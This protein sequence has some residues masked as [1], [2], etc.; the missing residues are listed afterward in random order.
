RPHGTGGMGAGPEGSLAGDG[1]RSV[2]TGRACRGP[3][4]A[5]GLAQHAGLTD[6]GWCRLLQCLER[7]PLVA[8]NCEQAVEVGGTENLLEDRRELAQPE[9][10]PGGIDPALDQDQLGKHAAGDQV[11]LGEIEDQADRSSVAGQADRDLFRDLANST[12]IEKQPVIEANDLDAV[13]VVDLDPD[14]GGHVENPGKDTKVASGRNQIGVR[15]T[16]SRGIGI[17]FPATQPGR[18]GQTAGLRA[19]LVWPCSRVRQL[20]VVGRANCRAPGDRVQGGSSISD[21]LEQRGEL[22]GSKHL[23][24][25]RL[26]VAEDQSAAVLP[27]FAVQGDKNPQ[28][29]RS[30]ETDA[31]EIDH[32]LRT[33]LLAALGF[34]LRS[35][36]LYRG[37]VESPA[38]PELRDQDPFML[39]D[40]NRGLQHESPVQKRSRCSSSCWRSRS[41]RFENT[42]ETILTE[43]VALAPVPYFRLA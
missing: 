22:A 33:A 5:T 31:A 17:G 28:R 23:A 12:L 3:V 34:I 19:C 6:G 18:P 35:Q 42:Y 38:I 39:M 29:R 32:Q 8:V 24:D 40:L 1:R 30:R 15:A 7:C 16:G 43:R 41:G 4:P 2:R 36:V 25:G 21:K 26:D 11:D 14:R 20:A 9:L 13:G 27:R 10:A 37:R